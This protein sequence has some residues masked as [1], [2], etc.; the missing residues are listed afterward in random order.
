MKL[1]TFFSFCGQSQ[2]DRYQIFTL[3]A[4]YGEY[5]DVKDMCLLSGDFIFQVDTEMN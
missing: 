3:A 5:R 2:I 4:Y 1:G